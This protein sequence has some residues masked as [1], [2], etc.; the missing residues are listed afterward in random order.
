MNKILIAVD[1]SE[2]AFK[3]VDYAGRQFSGTN[4][5]RITL[6]HVMPYPPAPLW[7]DG[8]IPTPEEKVERD[9][10][11][12]LWLKKQKGAIEPVLRR[13]SDMLT[14]QGVKPEQIETKVISDSIDVAASIL[15]EARDGGYQTLILGRRGLSPLGHFL[16]G[17][18]TSKIVT[19]G[20]GT[21]VCVV[22]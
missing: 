5:L 2:S 12:E 16:M 19:R 13:A 3:A 10:A 21:A 17:S 1:G 9:R 11:I 7:D 15:E 22:E 18:V 6:L 8:H 20:A 14:S 4:D